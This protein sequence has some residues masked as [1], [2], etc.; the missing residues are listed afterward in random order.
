MVIQCALRREMDLVKC[1]GQS[2]D[3]LGFYSRGDEEIDQKNCSLLG[4]KD[5]VPVL[6][7]NMPPVNAETPRKLY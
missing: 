2:K 7:N 4:F 1:T 5:S 6:S 3:E